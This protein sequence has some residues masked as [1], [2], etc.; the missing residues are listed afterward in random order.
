MVRM[1]LGERDEKLLGNPRPWLIFWIRDHRNRRDIESRSDAFERIEAGHA[2]AIHP[3]LDSL[4]GKA[5][6]LH[7]CGD[8]ASPFAESQEAFSEPIR[9]L[10][11]GTANSQYVVK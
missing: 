11:H 6:G 4:P 9:S 10:T 2:L 5:R 7:E 3:V 8:V 1:D